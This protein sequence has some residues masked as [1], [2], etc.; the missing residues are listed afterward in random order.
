MSFLNIRGTENCISFHPGAHGANYYGDGTGRD[1]SLARSWNQI[2]GTSDGMFSGGSHDMGSPRMAP[3][4]EGRPTGAPRRPL[5]TVSCRG[6][7]LQRTRAW[8]PVL[9]GQRTE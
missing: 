9:I 1:V 3:P 7:R 5:L 8:I 6:C 4:K 2:H